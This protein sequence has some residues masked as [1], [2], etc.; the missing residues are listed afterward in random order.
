[1]LVTWLNSAPIDDFQISKIDFSRGYPARGQCRMKFSTRA[2]FDEPATSL[3]DLISDFGKLE[4]VMVRRGA[5]VTRID[6]AQD[7][8]TALG[9]MVGFDWRGQARHM[10]LQVTRFDRPE[11]ISMWG[12]VDTFDVGIEMSVVA[13]NRA[14]SRLIVEADIRPKNMR[15]RLMVQ[16]AKLAKPQ[17]DRRFAR[18]INAFLEQMRTA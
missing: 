3:Y 1:M 8:G 13:L 7:P 16:T 15:A 14:R 10:H 4:R 11:R 17:L 9:W 2:D 18:K 12:Q 5:S 6:P